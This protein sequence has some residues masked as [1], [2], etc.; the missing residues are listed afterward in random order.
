MAR[1]L[2]VAHQTA[3]SPELLQ[4]LQT[5]V[6]NHPESAFVLLV[7]ATPIEDLLDWEDGDPQAIAQ[8]TAERAE[9]AWA[10]LGA[11]VIQAKVGDPSPLAA[12]TQELAEGREAYDGIFIS[13]L[14]VQ[15]S[16]WLSGD[17]LA[18]LERRFGL[19]VIHVASH[20]VTRSR[21]A[22][23]DGLNQDL[24]LELETVL[25]GVL[26]AA[27][28]RGM[29]GHELREMLKAELPSELG[30]AM[31]LA[32]KIVA[33]GGE[34]CMQPALP[35]PLSNARQLLPEHIA[36]ERRAVANYTRRIDQAAEYGDRGLVIRLEELLA[37]ETD[38]LEELERL[39]R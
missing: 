6:V 28:A 7:P 11:T 10:D 20:S 3:T 1:Y 2:V 18:R 25:R 29:L 26:H 15:R 27:A 39:A 17:L 4:A 14:P 12:I 13:T 33:L 8:R 30:H 19:P 23:I 24:N 5:Q 31:F 22:L 9:A 34:V 35:A 32:D 37:A 36:A 21:E 38:H 16:R